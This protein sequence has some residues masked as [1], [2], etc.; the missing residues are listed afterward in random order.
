MSISFTRD[1]FARGFR[2]AFPLGFGMIPFGL[3][4]GLLAARQG[5]SLIEAVLMSGLVFAGSSQLVALETWQANAPWLAAATAAFIDNLRFALMAPVAAPWL[6]ATPLSWRWFSV[7]TLVDHSFALSITE[8]RQGRNDAAFLPGAAA[9]L[10][11]WWIASTAAGHLGA[12]VLA[13]PRDHPLFFAAPA[14]FIAILLPM[15][16]GARSDAMPWLAGAATALATAQ[17][18]P[19]AWHIAA[20]GIVGATVGAL[21][22]RTRPA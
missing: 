19:G 13:I 7:G 4:T 2:V 20:G 22:D 17:L 1:G 5:F 21:R 11:C 15:W 8:M 10:W 14:A 6:R 18:L 12:G 9:S 16:R 3:I